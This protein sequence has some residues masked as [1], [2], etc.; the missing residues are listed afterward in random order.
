MFSKH[1]AENSCLGDDYHSY[2]L[3]TMKRTCE[4]YIISSLHLVQQ[5]KK[6]IQTVPE[7]RSLP[8]PGDIWNLTIFLCNTWDELCPK[9]VCSLILYQYIFSINGNCHLHGKR[10]SSEWIL[11]PDIIPWDSASGIMFF[12]CSVK[13]C[14]VC[15]ISAEHCGEHVGALWTACSLINLRN[16]WQGLHLIAKICL[17]PYTPW[18]HIEGTY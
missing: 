14:S 1:W 10:S 5:K 13:S 8:F 6:L 3:T 7:V 16:K 17:S 11:S 18:V 15:C 12:S 2:N 9:W 4:F